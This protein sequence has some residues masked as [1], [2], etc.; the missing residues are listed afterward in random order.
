MPTKKR[1]VRVSFLGDRRALASPTVRRVVTTV[2]DEEGVEQSAVSVTFLSP[3]RMRAL[4]RRT[5]ARDRATDV[6][7]FPLRHDAVVV[8]DVYVCPAVARR[9]ARR[10][11]V[12]TR[13]ELIRLVVH[14]TLHVLGYDH[15]AGSGRARSSMWERQERYVRAL[16]GAE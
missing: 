6:I 11:G 10:H 3:A 2:L 16:C 14:G 9:S 4:N 13:Q 15:P 8:G 12:P 1:D 7:G 5:F